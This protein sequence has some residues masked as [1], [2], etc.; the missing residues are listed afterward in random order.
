MGNLKDLSAQIPLK[1]RAL[2][3]GGPR[4]VNKL[5]IDSM[6]LVFPARHQSHWYP[7]R[8]MSPCAC[9][10]HHARV[11]FQLLKITR[12]HRGDFHTVRPFALGEAIVNKL[13]K[14]VKEVSK[15]RGHDPTACEIQYKT[16]SVLL[17]P[18]ESCLIS[19]E[20]LFYIH[21]NLNINKCKLPRKNVGLIFSLEVKLLRSKS[22]RWTVW[23]HTSVQTLLGRIWSGLSVPACWHSSSTVTY[24]WIRIR[25]NGCKAR[26]PRWI[27]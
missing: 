7:G 8:G 12:G 25:Q 23:R 21:Y 27:N 9:S 18:N 2:L 17:L 1:E 26:L 24:I 4:S 15:L 5:P 11:C 13:F 16:N 22:P 20:Y 3:S 10:Y 14:T 6:G 19:R